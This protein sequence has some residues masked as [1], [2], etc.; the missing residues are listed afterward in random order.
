MSTTPLKHLD[1]RGFLHN[2]EAIRN[3]SLKTLQKF[4]LSLNKHSLVHL[5]TVWMTTLLHHQ[6]YTFKNGRY[7]KHADQM[8]LNS[9]QSHFVKDCI[10]NQE[11]DSDHIEHH[12]ILTM[13]PEA[14]AYS[15]QFL[16]FREKCK[17]EGVCSN[18]I[19][20]N[21][22]YNTLSNYSIHID[23]KFVN[24]F[25][26]GYVNESRL[27]QFKHVCISIS[28]NNNRHGGEKGHS[29]FAFNRAL[30]LVIGNS[31]NSLKTLEFKPTNERDGNV[32]DT[33][34]SVLNN[35]LGKYHRLSV[36]KLIWREDGF[37]PSWCRNGDATPYRHSLQN[38][39]TYTA[40]NIC[41]KMPDLEEFSCGFTKHTAN[42][43]SQ[44]Y[45]NGFMFSV[46]TSSMQ[47]FKH[48]TTLDFHFPEFD[49]FE[50]YLQ[51]FVVFILGMVKLEKLSIYSQIGSNPKRTK[52]LTYPSLHQSLK[53]FHV[54]FNVVYLG[55]PS[56]KI[57]G[58]L[59]T[60]F[61]LKAFSSFC[62]IETFSFGITTQRQ[63]CF[64]SP[65]I[66]VYNM[67]P[68][69]Q[70]DLIVDW[71]LVF[72]ALFNA[73]RKHRCAP[74]KSLKINS[75]SDVDAQHV[76]GVL[77]RLHSETYFNLECFAIDVAFPAGT[78]FDIEYR[79][80]VDNVMIPFVNLYRTG[81]TSKDCNLKHLNVSW[82]SR[83]PYVQSTMFETHP[84]NRL[85]CTEPE[86]LYYKP[87]M[88]LLDSIPNT[89]INLK[90]KPPLL[91][92]KSKTL[93]SKN[94]QKDL[95]KQLVQIAVNKEESHSKLQQI[96]FQ[97]LKMSPK[98]LEFLQFFFGYKRKIYVNEHE[99]YFD[100]IDDGT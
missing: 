61:L 1:L 53:E 78:N 57:C 34:Y 52:Y 77:S 64:V 25:K 6:P 43:P 50:T 32:H 24:K 46:A 89:L 96:H 95:A 54:K 44:Q 73:K 16:T 12:T 15:M 91:W 37:A 63:V 82:G 55:D 36:K 28:Y 39:L 87:I 13:N 33:I 26:G 68:G 65:A 29:I 83:V 11:E 40:A 19:H 76:I 99:Y 38:V 2:E 98:R 90:I 41:L 72:T 60:A 30:R 51:D 10:A 88:N 7:I 4:M 67:I 21:R 66:A 9:M 17:L 31:L 62:K 69:R 5:I 22:K 20:I 59:V 85:K 18:F 81:P 45:F 35:I 80:F 100:F 27:R 8:I 42:R 92:K 75:I 3:I 49:I 56:F 70:M 23:R 71:Q 47:Q 74:L 84:Q 58:H 79:N 14:L 48:L 94:I 97:N 93:A 86:K